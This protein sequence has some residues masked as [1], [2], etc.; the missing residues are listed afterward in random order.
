MSPV[1]ARDCHPSNP[2]KCNGGNSK[3]E[4]H[5]GRPL[6][7]NWGVTRED[8]DSPAFMPLGIQPFKVCLKILGLPLLMSENSMGSYRNLLLSFDRNRTCLG[9]QSHETGFL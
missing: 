9:Y 5:C 1:G 3:Q 7:R 8:D 6:P 4:A 2:C